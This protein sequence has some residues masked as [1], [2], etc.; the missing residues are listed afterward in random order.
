MSSRTGRIVALRHGE[1]AWSRDGRHTGRTDVP[2]TAEG[3][4]RA[5]A[6]GA[7]LVDLRPVLVL[8]SPLQRARRT[9]E[10]AGLAP[11]LD[12]DLLEWDYG[13][14]EGR[15]T[16]E[17]RT[18]LGDPHWSV[19]TTATGLGESLSDVAARAERV[20]SRCRPVVHGGGVVVLVAHAHL[21][22]VLT[23]TWLRMPPAGGA[24]L[25]LEP[26]GTG[27]LGYE[28]ETPALLRWNA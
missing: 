28:R 16:T 11:E 13:D 4:R 23:A 10:L 20:L 22:R 15:T 14:Y 19:W 2:L 7:R 8:S 9:A 25:V 21:L 5:A 12:P 1:T 3:E 17:V 26:A 18:S 6:A 27:E 24:A